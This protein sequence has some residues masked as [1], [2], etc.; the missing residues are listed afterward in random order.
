MNSF[1][2]H[3][4]DDR[5]AALIRQTAKTRKSSVNKTLLHLLESSLGITKK[6]TSDH[7]NEFRDLCGVWSDKEK[8]EFEA[9][10]RPTSRIDA[11]DW[12]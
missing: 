1:S 10:A 6:E 11:E 9:H 8:R 4:V 12:K 7:S 2:L 5:L 3:N